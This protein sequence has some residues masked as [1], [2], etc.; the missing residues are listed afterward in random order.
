M[1]FELK[2]INDDFFSFG[3]SGTPA[4]RYRK[5]DIKR[6][7]FSN[8][9][10]DLLTIE[11]YYGDI[12]NVRLS[13]LVI[14]SSTPLGIT[15]ALSSLDTQVGQATTIIPTPTEL[16]DEYPSSTVARD[17]GLEEGEFFRTGE[18]VKQVIPPD[19]L[20]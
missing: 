18:F 1:T 6:Y 3:E 2:S 17:A 19:T 13:D 10:V 5:K 8:D 7:F 9:S 11:L 20:T 15:E 14:N 12:L 16:Y 4:I